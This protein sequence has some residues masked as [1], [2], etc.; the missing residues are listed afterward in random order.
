MRNYFSGPIIPGALMVSFSVKDPATFSLKDAATKLANFTG[1][2]RYGMSGFVCD[3]FSACVYY[4]HRP[5]R[6]R[7]AWYY[8]KHAAGILFG[9]G[10]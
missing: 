3:D 1:S 5:G 10:K 2:F 6:F 7:L 9:Y 4:N 8:A